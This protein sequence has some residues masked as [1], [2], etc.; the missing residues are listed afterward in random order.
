MVTLEDLQGSIQLLCMNDAYDKYR[1]LLVPN[2]AILVAGEISNNEDKPKIF[3][4]E[5][6]ALEDAPRKYTRQVHFRLHT[7][8]LTPDRIQLAHRLATAHPGDCPLFLCLRQPTGELVFIESHERFFV[9]PSM[10]LQ[11]AVDEAFGEETYYARVDTS[12]PERTPRRWERRDN[13]GEEG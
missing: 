10:Q 6:L 2:K 12:V 8:H 3:P 7:A 11:C 9:T 4:Q 1:D 5:I 13:G